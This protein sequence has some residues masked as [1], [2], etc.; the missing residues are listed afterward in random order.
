MRKDNELNTVGAGNFAFAAAMDALRRNGEMRSTYTS[1]QRKR[2]QSIYDLLDT[3]Y[4][5]KNM[6]MNFRKKFVSIKLEGA[7]ARDTMARDV[8]AMFRAEG[9]ERLVSAQGVIY[10][11]NRA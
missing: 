6:Y 5:Y 3:A 7:R 4:S 9:I 8:E 11:I 2:A 10:R 1:N